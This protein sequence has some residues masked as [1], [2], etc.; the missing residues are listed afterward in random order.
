MLVGAEG[1]VR[2][3]GVVNRIGTYPLAVMAKACKKPVYCVCERYPPH[4]RSYKFANIFPLNLKDLPIKY[5]SYFDDEMDGGQYLLSNPDIDLTPPE[6]ICLLFTNE[7]A[8]TPSS[9]G[10]LI[11]KGTE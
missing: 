7:G 1:V 5:E 8:L 2:N 11:V 9:V 6:Y 4:S 3:G 10:K